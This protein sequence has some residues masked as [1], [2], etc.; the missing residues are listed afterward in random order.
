LA[1]SIVNKG[2]DAMEWQTRQSCFFRQ[3]R[4]FSACWMLLFE[5]KK[6]V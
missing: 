2:L 1:K 4:G 3:M 6:A 5:P